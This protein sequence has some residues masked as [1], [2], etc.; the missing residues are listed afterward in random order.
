MNASCQRVTSSPCLVLA[1]A[2][3][4]WLAQT[5]RALRRVGWDAYATGSG[6]EAR[7]LA[8]LLEA[9]LVVLDTLLP[10]ESGWLTCEKLTRETP[11]LRVVLV[12]EAPNGRAMDLAAFVGAAALVGSGDGLGLLRHAELPAR[13]IV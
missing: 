11:G 9:D 8:R 12:D 4:D 13:G 1:H 10:G 7:R 3:A 6:P 5:A 2:D